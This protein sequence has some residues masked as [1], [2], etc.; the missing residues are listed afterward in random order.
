MSGR[1]PWLKVTAAIGG[2]LGV[3]Y[4]L[5]RV[6]TPTPEQLY[7]KMSPAVR[8]KVDESRMQRLAAENAA[9]Q[10]ASIQ[11]QATTSDPG[12]SKATSEEQRK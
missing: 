10:Q 4:V 11:A 5:M 12:A 7:E 6:V 1:F 3:G 8:R 9:R 2:C